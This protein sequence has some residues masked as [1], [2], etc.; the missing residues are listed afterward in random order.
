MPRSSCRR[1]VKHGGRQGE[2]SGLAS[3]ERRH[4]RRGAARSPSSVTIGSPRPKGDAPAGGRGPEPLTRI[5]SPDALSPFFSRSASCFRGRG[6]LRSEGRQD[7]RDRPLVN[8][9]TVGLAPPQGS[10][11]PS[12]VAPEA[13][14]LGGPRADPAHVSRPRPRR[15]RHPRSDHRVGADF[16]DM[17]GSGLESRFRGCGV[18]ATS[19]PVSYSCERGPSAKIKVDPGGAG[20]ANSFRRLKVST[21]AAS[22]V[23]PGPRALDRGPIGPQRQ[24]AQVSCAFPFGFFLNRS[25]RCQFT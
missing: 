23:G 19:G 7:E 3:T 16:L 21:F 25:E 15:R 18:G 4:A 17:Q 1:S 11:G 6:V 13:S 2:P 22:R 8:S 14:L 5:P 20:S 10:S 24:M 9:P 12:P